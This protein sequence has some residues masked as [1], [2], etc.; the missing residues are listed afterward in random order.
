[1]ASK[2]SHGTK[3]GNR[4]G[5]IERTLFAGYKVPDEVS[6]MSKLLK[7]ID[8]SSYRKIVV[9]VV[10]DIEG[11]TSSYHRVLKEVKSE[12]LP[13][14]NFNII[15]AGTKLLIASSIRLP[16]AS[17]KSEV[18][19]TDLQQ[20]RIPDEVIPYLRDAVYGSS[21]ISRS[22]VPN[23]LLE[24]TLSNGKIF[25]F[26]VSVAKFHELRYNIAKV[27]KEMNSVENKNILKIQD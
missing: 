25:T 22:L 13:I 20:M 14:D 11:D 8:H 7:K 4:P 12:E 16:D 6:K 19:E 10:K 1:M 5:A 15:F 3:P 18:F 21:T 2:V 17:L 24:L 23:L 27:L 26:E 9:A